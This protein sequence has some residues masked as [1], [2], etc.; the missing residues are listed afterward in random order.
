MYDFFG[1][2]VELGNEVLIN[3]Y[4]SFTKAKIIKITAK[5]IKIQKRNKHKTEKYIYA[6][7]CVSLETFKRI[8][9]E[10]FL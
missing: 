10:L 3:D 7:Q 6:K 5:M 4:D 8:S 2:Q 1:V 9:P